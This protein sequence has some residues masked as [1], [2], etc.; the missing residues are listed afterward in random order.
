MR[1]ISQTAPQTNYDRILMGI[2]LL[3]HKSKRQICLRTSQWQARFGACHW[4]IYLHHYPNSSTH[5]AVSCCLRSICPDTDFCVDCK[6][7]W[8]PAA[9]FEVRRGSV[10]RLVAEMLLGWNSSGLPPYKSTQA[11]RK[12]LPPP[13]RNSLPYMEIRI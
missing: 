5:Q 1:R 3:F 9:C 11:C 6:V 4:F 7:Y 2:L 12:N 8:F 13:V 10:D